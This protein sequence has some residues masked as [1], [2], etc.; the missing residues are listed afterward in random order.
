MYGTQGKINNLK[1]K[2]MQIKDFIINLTGWVNLQAL[3]ESCKKYNRGYFQVTIPAKNVI[4]NLPNDEELEYYLVVDDSKFIGLHAENRFGDK[5]HEWFF[6]KQQFI[7]NL[8]E[9]K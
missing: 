5:M 6:T 2:L 7:K 8:E 9:R 1:N 3:V 4:E